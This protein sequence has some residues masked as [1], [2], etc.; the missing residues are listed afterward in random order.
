MKFAT[1]ILALVAPGV[2]IVV[3]VLAVGGLAWILTNPL[4]WFTLVASLALLANASHRER[5][6]RPRAAKRDNHPDWDWD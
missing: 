2:L 3:L 1:L 5:S 6:R 4:F